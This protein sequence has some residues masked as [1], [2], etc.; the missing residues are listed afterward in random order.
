LVNGA[1]CSRHAIAVLQGKI[2]EGLESGKSKPFDP[3]E[4][5]LRM[6]ERHLVR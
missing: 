6:R 4:F 3:A 1:Q 5:K 2:T